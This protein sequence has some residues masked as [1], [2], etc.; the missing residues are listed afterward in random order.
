MFINAQTLRYGQ[1]E[2]EI[3]TLDYI[4]KLLVEGKRDAA[5]TAAIDRA[6][7]LRLAQVPTLAPYDP[8]AE[9]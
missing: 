8:R 6:D 3:A 4:V 7:F 2:D 9:A 1:H 5:M